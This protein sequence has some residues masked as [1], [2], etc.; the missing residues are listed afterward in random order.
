MIR[1]GQEVNSN[2]CERPMLWM[3]DNSL[4]AHHTA[5]GRCFKCNPEK[6]AKEQEEFMKEARAKREFFKIWLEKSKEG[7]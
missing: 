7:K 3:S 4:E 5:C 1:P 2:E 6:W